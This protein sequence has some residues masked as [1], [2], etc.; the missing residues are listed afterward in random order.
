M[1]RRSYSFLLL[2]Q[3]LS[4]ARQWSTYLWCHIQLLHLLLCTAYSHV[5]SFDPRQL[6]P[7]LLCS[8]GLSSAFFKLWAS[9]S[10]SAVSLL[11]FPFCSLFFRQLRMSRLLS[12]CFPLIFPPNLHGCMCNV[13]CTQGTSIT[14]NSSPSF[15]D[16]FP[17][18][19]FFFSS[20]CSGSLRQVFP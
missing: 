7:Y 9:Q 3:V 11:A 20:R 18:E 19:P 4:S 15:R 13:S 14:R 2:S 10:V 5:V 12:D 8:H 1:S 16:L 6:L 17:Q